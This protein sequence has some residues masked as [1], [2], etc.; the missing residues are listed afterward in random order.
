MNGSYGYFKGTEAIDGDAV[1][2]FIGPHLDSDVV[3]AVDQYKGSTFDETKFI[4]GTRSEKAGIALYLSNYPKG[5]KL[6]PVSVLT[7]DQLKSWL[8][9]GKTKKPFAGQLQKSAAKWNTL[10]TN[11]RMNRLALEDQPAFNALMQ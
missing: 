3:V 10:P 11:P 9:D 2:C 6:G 1:D 7:V 4:L 8:S 5:W